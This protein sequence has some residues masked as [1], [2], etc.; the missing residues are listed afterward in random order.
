M[1]MRQPAAENHAPYMVLS[2]SLYQNDRLKYMPIIIS[3]AI[4]TGTT[5]RPGQ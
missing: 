1:S 5:L 3:A 4:T 2:M